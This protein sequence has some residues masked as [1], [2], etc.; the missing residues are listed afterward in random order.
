MTAEF[1][2]VIP[3][4]TKSHAACAERMPAFVG[5]EGDAL[6]R[7]RGMRVLVAGVGSVG[8]RL[9][10]DLARCSL[11][12]LA[13]V[14]PKCFSANFRTQATRSRRDV[15]RAKARRVARWACEVAD[16]TVVRWFDGP[17]EALPWTALTAYDAIV[18]STDLIRA[19]IELGQR[20]RWLGVPLLYASV[21]GPTLTA[22]LRVYLNRDESSPCP[23]C[24]LS[25]AEWA[26]LDAETRFS[27]DGSGQATGGG[28]PTMSIAPLCGTAAHMAA[29][30]LLRIRLGLGPAPTDRI[31]QHNFYGSQTTSS[32]LAAGTSCP[33]DH[34]VFERVVPRGPAAE[35]TLRDCAAMAGAETDDDL[36]RTTV[37]IDDAV[38]ART[39]LCPHC[40]EASH[41]GRLL[42]RNGRLD[43]RCRACRGRGLIAHPYHAYAGF[44]PVQAAGLLDRLDVPLQRLGAPGTG[45]AVRTERRSVLITPHSGAPETTGTPATTGAT[46]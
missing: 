3:K 14:D 37:C 39:L 24:H 16:S 6:E 34:T 44:V 20:A 1:H 5:L 43:R 35:L 33:C 36:A 7:L 12:E 29:I 38:Y 30:E 22:Q 19:E 26:Q 40:G 25:A 31:V 8:S 4:H 9:S 42:E 45:I 27:C 46:T 15:G 41:G 2:T 18:A 10:D 11:A 21:H 28:P 23:A 32:P 13:L 17:V